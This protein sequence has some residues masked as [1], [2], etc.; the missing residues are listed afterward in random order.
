MID[1][2]K[3]VVLDVE[4]NG[5]NSTR[6]DLLSIS[7]YDP[8]NN[9]SYDRFLPLDKNSDIYTTHINGITKEMLK[10]QTHI[11]QEEFDSL[12]VEFDLY[13]R[14][15]LTYGNI[16]KVFLKEYCNRHKISGFDKLLF[17]NFKHKIISSSFSS[18]I[19]SKDNLCN[20]FKIDNVNEIH[21]GHND[22]IL[23]W[24]L[25]KK[26][27]DRFLLITYCDV[28]ELN[29]KYI[30]P[31]SILQTYGNF[32]YYRKIPKVYIRTK[33]VKKFQL[34]KRRVFRFDTNVSGISIEHLINTLL[35]VKKIDSFGFELKNKMNLKYLG[36]LPSPYNEIPIILNK[37]GTVS[38]ISPEH[39]KYI[40]QVNKTTRTLQKQIEPLIVYIKSRIFKNDPILSQELIVNEEHN[41]SAK[42]DLSNNNAVLEIKMGHNLDFDNIK[43][44]LYYES[45]NRPTYVLHF[46]WEKKIFII[47]KVDFISEEE[48][49]EE[50]NNKKIKK[51]TKQFQKKINNKSVKVIEYVNSEQPVKLKCLNCNYEW[52]SKYNK[53]KN[54]Q[55]CPK[56]FPET[57]TIHKEKKMVK[58]KEKIDYE[59]KFS[60]SVFTKSNGS[61]AVLK[62]NGSKSNAEV[63]CLKCYY[64]WKIR[65]DHLLERCYCPKCR[66]NR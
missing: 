61:I 60:E 36:T 20:L 38:T 34:I 22:C 32:K 48:Y 31:A 4:T 21:T 40:E 53:I 29:D 25:F 23:E 50:K 33:D 14:T 8:K 52:I 26:V 57:Q 58:E 37:D 35:D 45:N 43:I 13:N 41:I 66:N 64:E 12:V 55:L 7:I 65:P 16:D 62:Y 63:G 27:Y 39:E 51:S 17:F 9:K 46:D 2:S 18:G 6:F 59:K 47:T 42:C 15:I 24:E 30:I 11:T 1:S 10:G 54:C 5:L 49:R 56:C 3:Y 19:V 44:Q 28:F